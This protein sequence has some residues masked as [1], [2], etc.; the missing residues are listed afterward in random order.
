MKPDALERDFCEE[1]SSAH[2]SLK[3]LF[4]SFVAL[5]SVRSLCWKIILPPLMNSGTNPLTGEYT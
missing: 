5:T 2:I 4:R 3:L 1:G